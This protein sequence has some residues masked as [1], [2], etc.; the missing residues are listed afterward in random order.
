ME[1]IGHLHWSGSRCCRRGQRAHP[2]LTGRQRLGEALD[3]WP[4]RVLVVYRRNIVSRACTLHFPHPRVVSNEFQKNEL[5]TVQEG[6]PRENGFCNCYPWGP[7]PLV[8]STCPALVAQC[9]LQLQH[10]TGLG[11]FWQYLALAFQL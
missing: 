7:G 1:L 11:V 4:L 6:E 2:L 5:Q 10:V 3:S 8:P 9:E